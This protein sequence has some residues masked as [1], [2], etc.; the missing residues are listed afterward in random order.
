MVITYFNMRNRFQD[1]LRIPLEDDG[2]MES[3]LDSRRQDPDN[4]KGYIAGMAENWPGEFPQ[5]DQID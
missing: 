4:L 2:R 1:A 3:I 5:A